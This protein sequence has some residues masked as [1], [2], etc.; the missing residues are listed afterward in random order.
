MKPFELFDSAHAE[1]IRQKLIESGS[2]FARD[3]L[4]YRSSDRLVL[5]GNLDRVDD[6]RYPIHET[7]ELD[8]GEIE[9]YDDFP[10]KLGLRVSSFFCPRCLLHLED[11]EEIQL[12]SMEDLVTGIPAEV[13][14]VGATDEDFWLEFYNSLTILDAAED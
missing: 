11:V 1:R 14:A 7:V 8:N 10:K 4:E 13:D 5:T 9:E 6:K 3:A 2:R 12:A